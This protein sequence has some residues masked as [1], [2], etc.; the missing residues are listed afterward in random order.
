[1]SLK[2][3]KILL[4]ITGSIAAYKSASL[5]RLLIKAGADVKV[6]MTK[7]A[8][9]FISPLTLSTLSKHDVL[10]DISTD[11]AWNNHVEL[12]LWADVMIIAPLSA[13]TLSKMSTGLCDNLLMAVYLSAKCP[14]F[15]APAMDLDMWK[16]P[17]TLSNIESIQSYGNYM[18]DVTYGELA[19]GLVGAG[20]M[21][22]PEDIVASLSEH[23]GTGPL[24][25]KQV[26]ITA[27]PTYEKIDPVRFIGNRSTG[28]MGLAIAKRC[29]A[30]GADVT[31]VMGPNHLDIPSDIEV[32]KVES[33]EQMYEACEAQFDK[34]DLTFLSAAVADFTP[35]TVAD[36][37]IKKKGDGMTLDLAKTT[38][39]AASLGQRKRKNQIVVGFALETNDE[40]ANAK[41]KLERKNF[42]FIVLNSMKD[43]GATFGYDTNK[44]TIISKGNK[45]HNYELKSKDAVARDILDLV[46]AAF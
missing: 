3:K 12:G 9:D 14:V 25:D 2:G 18:V 28:K 34:A 40:M 15:F 29:T 11:E 8:T 32:I 33:A 46:I 42:D 41:S 17:S 19:S 39:I 13:N 4:G 44:V 7:A 27:G 23:F 26:L 24:T 36:Q 1:M 6:V 31:M 16:H 43:K 38:D 30:L 37:K 10:S 20:R 22:E 5:T 45:I 35:K 21:A